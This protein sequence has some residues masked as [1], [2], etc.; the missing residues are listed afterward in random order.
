MGTLAKKSGKRRANG[1]EDLRP[2]SF[3]NWVKWDKRNDLKDARRPGIYIIAKSK[4][5]LTGTPFSWTEKIMYIG[6]SAGKGG[7]RNRMRQFDTTLRGA[8]KSHGGASRVFRR[9]TNR[10]VLRG[11]LYVSIMPAPRS[12]STKKAA[13]KTA[14]DRVYG[15]ELFCLTEYI[16]RHRKIPQFNDWAL[17]PK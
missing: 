12:R 8:A 1:V 11:Y 16:R 3:T 7:L 4:L 10:D 9:H 14:V 15:L 17:S 2:Y 5:S 6:M 13:R